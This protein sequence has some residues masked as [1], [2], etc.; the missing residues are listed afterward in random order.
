[1]IQGARRLQSVAHATSTTGLQLI[2][3]SADMKAKNVNST[4]EL[5]EY[6]VMNLLG[7]AKACA[8]STQ[9]PFVLA[10]TCGLWGFADKG[11]ILDVR[12]SDLA[13]G[14]PIHP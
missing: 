9:I 12:N 3:A 6:V 7:G 1:M 8:E 10:K 4:T 5:H 13:F 11:S 14:A 2:H